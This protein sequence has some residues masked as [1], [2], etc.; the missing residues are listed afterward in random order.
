[1]LSSLRGMDELVPINDVIS[2]QW[3]RGGLCNELNGEPPGGGMG[4][5]LYLPML[6]LKMVSKRIKG[7]IPKK[8]KETLKKIKLKTDLVL[9]WVRVFYL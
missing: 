5:E 6:H 1:M 9:G 2:N 8:Q 7:I 3:L 4:I